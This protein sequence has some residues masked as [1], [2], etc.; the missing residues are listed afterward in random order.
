LTLKNNVRN[1]PGRPPRQHQDGLDTRDALIRC[2]VEILT[3][4]SFAATSLGDIL[5]RLDVPKGSFYHYFDS[6]EAFGSEVIDSYADYFARKLDRFLKDDTVD[7]LQRLAN[8]IADASRGMARHQFQRGCLIGNLG[9]EMNSLPETFRV[10]LENTFLD[11]Q[12][13]LAKCLC[14]ARTRGDLAASADCEQLAAFFWIGW[15]GAVLRAKLISDVTPLMIFANGYFAGLP[16]NAAT[17]L[18]VAARI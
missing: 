8:F 14:L 13:R 18:P 1:G 15:E 6:K 10:K 4:R 11:W 3:E 5:G 16:R 12:Q 7:P 9:Q 2:G 17:P